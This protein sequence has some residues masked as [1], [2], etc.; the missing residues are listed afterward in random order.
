MKIKS[1]KYVKNEENINTSITVIKAD[2]SV[3]HVPLVSDN[4]DYCE[5]IKQVEDKTLTIKDAD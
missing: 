3:I 4:I 2:D 5:I 1:A